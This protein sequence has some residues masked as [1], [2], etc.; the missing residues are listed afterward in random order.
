MVGDANPKIVQ[1][2]LEASA[3][4]DEAGLTRAIIAG[5]PRFSTTQRTVAQSVLASRRVSAEALLH[6]VESGGI[7]RSSL[8]A[9]MQDK[10][11]RLDGGAL[12]ARV[13]QIFGVKQT[14]S[15][16]AAEAEITRVVSTISSGQGSPYR[17]RDLFDQ[18][19]AG[20]HR[21]HNKGG[22]V[23]P[24]LTS[25]KRDD[26]PTLIL[27]IVNPSAEIREGYES[28]V[29]TTKQGATHAGFLTT[30]DAQR[31]VLRDMAGITLSLPRSDIAA[32]SSLGRS[33]MPD[34]LLGDLSAAQLRDLFAYVRSTQPLVGQEE[35]STASR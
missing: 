25:Y 29:I 11:R 14:Q 13:D 16:A 4:Y 1:A 6:A 10:V 35:A 23:G 12:A 2:A 27:S 32:M 26:I 19:C 7:E 33:L 3:S 20:C 9:E 34:G 18:R 17:G 30:Q 22:K 31:V 8:P 28:V 5:L 15:F 21:L 24:D